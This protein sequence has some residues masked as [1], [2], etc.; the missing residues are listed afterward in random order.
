MDSQPS[1]ILRRFTSQFWDLITPWKPLIRKATFLVAFLQFLALITPYCSAFIVDGIVSRSAFVSEHLGL[2]IVSLF[3]I[4]IGIG[5]VQVR[6]NR[7]IYEVLIAVE[8]DLPISCGKKLLSL[9]LSYHQTENTGAIIGK[10]VRGVGKTMDLIA[11]MLYEIIPLAIQTVVTSVILIAL[12]WRTALILVPIIFS[13]TWI[14][15]RTKRKW[16]VHRMQRHAFDG[17]ADDLLGQA[18]T[19][20]MTVQAFAQEPREMD[21][22][23][24]IR[25]R[26]RRMARQEFAAY[27]HTDH[28]RNGLI[29][30]GRT[31]ILFICARAAFSDQLSMGTLVFISALTEKVF[32]SCYRIGAVFD[33]MMEAAEPVM[34][35]TTIFSEPELV[36]DPAEPKILPRRIAGEIEFRNVTY[37]YRSRLEPDAVRHPA[38]QDVNLVI[39]QGETIGIVG[40]SGGGKSTLVKL[41]MRFNDPRTLDRNTPLMVPDSGAVLIDGID[42]RELRLHDF[43]RRIG[44]V[45][46]EVE[47]FDASV[48]ENIAYGRPDV[49]RAEIERAAKIAHAH[50]F[51]S[52][53][54]NGY[55]ERVGNRG[56][57][58][59]GGQRQR[60]GIARAVLL[61]PAILV[62]DEAT[63]HVDTA[64]ERKIQQAIE[65]LRRGRTVLIIAHRLS[66]IQSANRII[67]MEDGRIQETGTHQELVR[68]NG[69][70]GRLVELQQR[71]DA[72]L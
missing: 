47:I 21:V 36:A 29:S 72:T 20:V 41:L 56:L 67:V 23:T 9:P 46:Q 15:I 60:I 34:R 18:V 61:D 53:L 3:I 42:L 33:R 7:S 24:Q 58:L 48:A 10:L 62:F 14:T 1:G 16:S 50:G 17:D 65:T 38:L 27:D 59:S 25:D 63:S 55:E 2:L 70:Y 28:M 19:N 52:S 43:R 31:C 45:P 26:V 69:L 39:R 5:W 13:F 12:G 8:R 71:V 35:I 30:L 66:T 40:E 57:R 68:H 32:M 44:Y 11:V 64:T 49:T 4:E 51:I 37:T 6:K 22:V 54:P